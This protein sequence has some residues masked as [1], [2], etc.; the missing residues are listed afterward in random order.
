MRVEETFIAAIKGLLSSMID[1]Y[2]VGRKVYMALGIP[3]SDH[4]PTF[5][6]DNFPIMQFNRSLRRRCSFQAQFSKAFSHF[7]S[8]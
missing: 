8:L 4:T 2:A 1:R 3:W 6:T 7:I 5:T